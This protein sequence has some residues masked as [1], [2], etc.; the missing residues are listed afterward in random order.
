MS[1]SPRKGKTS[2]FSIGLWSDALF[3][4]P[5][6]SSQ[7]LTILTSFCGVAVA[8]EALAIGELSPTGRAIKKSPPQLVAGILILF[9]SAM[10]LFARCLY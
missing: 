1:P 6:L 8:R 4:T 9:N 10:Q 2:K 7:R 5:C 3:A